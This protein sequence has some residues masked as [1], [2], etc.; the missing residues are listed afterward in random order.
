MEW[1]FGVLTAASLCQVWDWWCRGLAISGSVPQLNVTF[2]TR[3]QTMFIFVICIVRF[4][5]NPMD[6][7]PLPATGRFY[8][9]YR[10]KHCCIVRSEYLYWCGQSLRGLCQCHGRAKDIWGDFLVGSSAQAFPQH[11]DHVKYPVSP[12]TPAAWGVCAF[13]AWRK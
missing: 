6:C 13:H 5:L 12:Y 1:N 7:L 8:P 9:V 10:A 2:T 3:L 4:L 11:H